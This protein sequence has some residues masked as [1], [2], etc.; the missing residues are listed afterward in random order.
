MTSTTILGCR[1]D[2]YDPAGAVERI[3]ELAR[4]DEPASVVTLGTE[5]V[6]HARTDE[7]FRAAVNASALSLCDTIGV[8][9]AARAAGLPLRER[10]AGIDLVEPLCRRLARERL[11][12]YLLGGRG[13][14]AERAASVLATRCP[15]LIVAGVRDGYFGPE[16]NGAVAAAVAATGARVLLLGLGFPRQELWSAEHLAATGARVGIGVG[17]SFDVLSGNVRRA[18]AAFRRLHGEWLYR[19]LSEPRRLRRQLALPAFVLLA[20]RERLSGGGAA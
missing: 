3:V 1:V 6:V 8:L 20:A 4:G 13:D 16:E 7:R 12:I 10:V 15:G 9:Y 18:P 2:G 5:M 17:G 14:T 19:L 11:S